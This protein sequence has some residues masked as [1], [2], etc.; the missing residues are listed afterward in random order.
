MGPADDK[1]HEECGVFGAYDPAGNDVAPAI[2][3]GLFAL[4]HRGPVS[5]THLDVYKRQSQK[6][7][8]DRSAGRQP[9]GAFFK[10]VFDD[11]AF[12][13]QPFKVIMNRRGRGNPNFTANFPDG[14]RD[15]VV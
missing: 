14:G 13:G 6:R 8:G 12:L 1:P 2:S 4:Q 15:I 7:D 5:Y 9:D 10:L 11:I 3:Y